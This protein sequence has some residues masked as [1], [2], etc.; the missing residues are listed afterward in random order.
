[1]RRATLPPRRSNAVLDMV[2]RSMVGQSIMD[3]DYELLYEYLYS[4]FSRRRTGA[5]D[6]VIVGIRH[7]FWMLTYAR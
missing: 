6:L 5:A 2:D 3:G 7:G 4:L 1:M